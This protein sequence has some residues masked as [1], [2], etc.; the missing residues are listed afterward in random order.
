MQ[1][2]NNTILNIYKKWKKE[3]T[4][5]RRPTERELERVDTELL[6]TLPIEERMWT[7]NFTGRKTKRTPFQKTYYCKCGERFYDQYSYNP[8]SYNDIR[9]ILC[10][11]CFK[12]NYS[13]HPPQR[14]E[15]RT[16]STQRTRDELI[17]Q[18]FTLK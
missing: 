6:N 3:Q 4:P 13:E 2:E 11:H 12:S 15:R 16:V 1:K 14:R 7:L 17:R 8:R 9:E 18:Y 5:P 10:P